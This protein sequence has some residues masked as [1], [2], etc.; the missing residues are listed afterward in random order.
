MRAPTAERGDALGSALER[1]VQQRSES[2]EHHDDPGGPQP[3]VLR[4]LLRTSPSALALQGGDRDQRDAGLPLPDRDEPA[5]ELAE[6]LTA[7]HAI[8]PAVLPSGPLA[9]IVA[10]AATYFW[11]QDGVRLEI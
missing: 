5:D 2:D 1:E 9:K 10:E 4:P 11:G 7:L 6:V 8:N 3:G